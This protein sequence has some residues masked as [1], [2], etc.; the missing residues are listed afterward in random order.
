M[1]R[2]IN[3]R[4]RKWGVD[5]GLEP[6]PAEAIVPLEQTDDVIL[7]TSHYPSWFTYETHIAELAYAHAL[8][9]RDRPFA[10]TEDPSEVFEKTVI[11]FIPDRGVFV[12]R[13][14]DY[15][16][17]V[18]QFVVGL[19][20]Q[21][22][23]PLCSSHEIAF[24]ENKA[25][26][27]RKLDEIG[28]PTPRTKILS[29]QDW[30]GAEFDIEPVLIKEEH[31]A[32]SGGIHHFDTAGQA[33]SFVAEYPFRPSESLIMQELVR[34]ANQDLRL[35]MAGR[36][37]IAEATYWRRKRPDASADGKWTTTATT[38]GSEVIHDDVPPQSG[39]L[40]AEWLE[41]LEIRTAG[42]DLMWVDDDT[43]AEP[44]ILELSPYY[45]PNPPKPERYAD[46]TYKEYKSKRR[47][48]A[49]GYRLKQ[50]E[51]FRRVAGELLDQD[52]L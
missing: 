43:S 25:H 44:K 24:W 48:V 6:M 31:S 28:A 45:Q 8:A 12:P 11:W 36:S 37:P 22:N 39:S 41:K 49:E 18:H 15:S 5:R 51:A 21:G 20:S 14:W 4:Y 42:I 16:R 38:Y 10:I 13:L 26:M 23:R 32:G 30:E 17:Q 46:L 27:H 40:A 2:K 50:Y 29:A 3:G 7:L 35:T 1:L 52:L 19:E 9:A 33:R 34:G 47:N